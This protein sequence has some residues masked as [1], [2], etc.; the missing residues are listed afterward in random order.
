MQFWKDTRTVDIY[1]GVVAVTGPPGRH[2]IKQAKLLEP[3]NDGSLVIL[4]NA[5]GTGVITSLLYEMLGD[6]EREKLQV[7]CGDFSEGMVNAV[8]EMIETCGWKGAKAQLIDAQV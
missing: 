5:C 7:I 3:S 1:R 8:Q 2:L 4:D 6:G